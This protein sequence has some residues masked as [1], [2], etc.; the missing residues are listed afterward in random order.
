MCSYFTGA[1]YVDGSNIILKGET[2][3]SNNTAVFGGMTSVDCEMYSSVSLSQPK[4]C[5]PRI[6]FDRVPREKYGSLYAIRHVYP[7]KKRVKR[8]RGAFEIYFIGTCTFLVFQMHACFFSDN[9]CL[10]PQ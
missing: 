10:R 2:V 8:S 9:Y 3:F 5:F 1:V 4:G 7:C 6:V